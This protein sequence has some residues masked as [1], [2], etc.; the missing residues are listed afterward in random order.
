MI[1]PSGA[2]KTV[3]QADGTDIAGIDAVKIIRLDHKGVA[4]PSPDGV[5]VP[6]RLHLSETRKRTAI[7][8]DRAETVI[9]L[10]DVQKFSRC[11]DDFK[12]LRIDVVL[13]RTLRKAQPIR[14]VQAI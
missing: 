12:R 5:A 8:V 9:G 7:H 11:L 2:E 3:G 13:K 6:I 14:I 4:F 1:E 10:G